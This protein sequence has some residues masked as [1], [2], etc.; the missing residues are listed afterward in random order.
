MIGV[1][2]TV[3]LANYPAEM[4]VPTPPPT[5]A[6]VVS[7]LSKS[8]GD[9]RAVDD[10]SLTI[11]AGGFFGIC[12]P[13][14]AGKTTMLKMVTGLLKPD[15]GTVEVDGVDV[16]TDPTAAKQRFG[17]VPDNPSL[18]DRLNGPEVLEFTGA[19]RGMEPGL[20]RERSEQILAALDLEKDRTTLIADYSLGMTKRIGL[21]TAI[22]HNPRV[23]ILDEP[24]GSLDPVNTS[25]MEELL[26]L[27][28]KGGGTVVFSSHVMD[29]V[30]RLCDDIVIIAEGRV[31]A[32]GTVAQVADGKRLQD[33]F[34]SLV[35]G[36]DLDDGSLGW[37]ASSS[38]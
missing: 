9:K 22:L 1:G 28:R 23:L 5:P 21:A 13:N 15:S 24:F 32:E 29:V 35:G 6:V 11:P 18:F 26:Q 7:G 36:R 37:L 20:V 2:V 17:F 31:L 33:A 10:L 34:V 27:H 30:E 38:D 25:V 16:W 4:T 12:G 3:N 14:G 19:L 8:F